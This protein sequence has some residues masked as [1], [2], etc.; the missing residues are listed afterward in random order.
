M[1]ENTQ[2]FI[3]K[4]TGLAIDAAIQRRGNLYLQ[5]TIHNRSNQ[6]LEDFDIQFNRNYFGLNI[7]AGSLR[8]LKLQPNQS[9]DVNIE[10]ITNITPDL[11]KLP[12][13]NPPFLLQTAISCSLDEFYFT[14]PI[15]FSVLFEANSFKIGKDEYNQIW[16]NIQTTSDMC[17]NLNNINY[18]NPEAA[19]ER[20]ENNSINL[21]HRAQQDNG[22]RNIYFN[23]F[24]FFSYFIF[25]C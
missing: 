15:I 17:I 14:I 18:P 4:V 6:V 22:Q 21:I 24:I 1:N 23:I 2:G 25:Q 5:M 11:M 9:E 7:T 20:L 10:V 13:Y 12:N 16:S 8:G 3:Q 19:I